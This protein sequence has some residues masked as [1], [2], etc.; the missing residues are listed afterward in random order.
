MQFL[1]LGTNVAIQIV[2]ARKNGE[3]LSK[4]DLQQRGRVS[5]TIIE[6]MDAMGCLRR[7]T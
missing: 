1:D 6:Y 2:K 4:E 5:K 7:T 3:F